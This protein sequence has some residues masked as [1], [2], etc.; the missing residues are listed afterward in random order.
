MIF[1]FGDGEKEVN[2]QRFVLQ[3]IASARANGITQNQLSKE[4]GIEENTFF[5]VVRKLEKRGLIVRQEAVEKTRGSSKQKLATRL[6]HLYRYAKH[7]GSQEKFEVTKDE[8]SIGKED[9]EDVLINDYLPSIKT[10]CD[11][12]EETHGKV[13]V[14][15]GIKRDLDY[16]GSQN[17][18]H[19]WKK[20]HLLLFLLLMLCVF[21]NGF[22][23]F[24]HLQI[25][26]IDIL[27]IDKC[28]FSRGD[29]CKSEWEDCFISRD[30][31]CLHL[32]KKFC[33]L[34]YERNTTRCVE[35]KEFKFGRCQ[36]ANQLVE[37]PID[38]Q[39]YDTIDATGSKG[40]LIT[41]VGKRFGIIRR[42]IAETV[43]Q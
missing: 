5:Y 27:Q 23:L 10:I 20:V 14:I 15:S 37:L 4:F 34:D 18:R 35:G 13:L 17:A 9:S 26:L 32:L 30:E 16:F 12:L 36:M 2:Q 1:L 3:R 31:P 6:I 8:G 43:F 24:L 40:M 19:E 42:R 41:E 38:H 25:F 7:L 28:W 33:P 29:Y 39:I 21:L 11:K 22:H